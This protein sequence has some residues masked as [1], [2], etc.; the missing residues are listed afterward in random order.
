M[1]DAEEIRQKYQGSPKEM[2][3][4][5]RERWEKALNDADALRSQI[6]LLEKQ[7]KLEAWAKEEPNPAPVIGVDGQK[8]TAEDL[9][10]M[11]KAYI[12]VLNGSL[13]GHEFRDLAIAKGWSAGNPTGAGAFVMPVEFAS[14]V[15]RLVQDAV[16]IRGYAKH[17]TVTSAESLGV[18]TVGDINDFDWTTELRTGSEETSNPFGRRDFFPKPCA[19]RF[20]ISR[21]LLRMSTKPE[22]EWNRLAT[23][24][25]SRTEEKAFIYGTGANQP[26]G[27]NV[28]NAAGVSS[29]RSVA[30]GT[31]NAIAADD[32]W[33]VVALLKGSYRNGARWI[34]HR[35]T[36]AR[37]RMLKDGNNNYIWSPLGATSQGLVG[38]MA[39]TIA[40]FPYDLSEFM[41]DPAVSGNITT[42]TLV[43]ALC[44]YG[45]GY[46]IV[47]ALNMEVQVLN[48]LYAETNEIGY[49]YRFETDGAP[50]DEEAFARLKIS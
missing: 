35:N 36:E 45:M 43:M 22:A 28:E 7:E 17:D 12:A 41:P 19:K 20:K 27:F 30:S 21:K 11:K 23:Y 32:I 48:E 16:F 33:K 25:R 47:D 15:L 8:K 18:I 42:G 6:E 24:V 2:P 5:E 39:P 29:S 26:L 40:G 34:F 1:Q 4:D 50:D 37:L 10:E 14:D 31:A 9:A 3:G 13:K 44:N 38:G 46:R 49:I